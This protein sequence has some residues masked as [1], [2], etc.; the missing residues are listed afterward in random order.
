MWCD[1][2]SIIYLEWN[3]FDESMKYHEIVF[4]QQKM[5]KIKKNMKMKKDMHFLVK[6][7][8]TIE[9]GVFEY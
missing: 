3:I 6:L 2:E 8:K 4:S 7:R 1:H 9:F 5:N